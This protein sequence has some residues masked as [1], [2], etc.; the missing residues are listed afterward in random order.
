MG[1]T[2]AEGGWQGL[3]RVTAE[4][5]VAEER[6]AGGGGGG[7]P[8]GSGDGGGL[9]DATPRAQPAAMTAGVAAAAANRGN[10]ALSGLTQRQYRLVLHRRSPWPVLVS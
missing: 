9:G 3:S 1:R 8:D 4:D 7:Q 2:T 5:V 6:H 10:A